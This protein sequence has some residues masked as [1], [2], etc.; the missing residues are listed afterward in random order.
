MIERDGLTTFRF[1][2]RP[3][4]ASEIAWRTWGEK[5]FQE[6]QASEKPILLAISAVWCH[7]CHVM[8]ETSYSDDEVIRTIN[9][10]YV[11]IRV[12]NDERPD[13][14]RRYNMGG[15]PTTA[16]LT[17]DGE[18]V[19]GGTYIPPDAMRSY[20]TQVADVWR[21]RRTE[22]AQRVAEIREKEREARAPKPADLSWDIVD[23]V[24]SHIRGAYDP[25]F[26]GFGR[27]PKFPQP[28]V[29]RF[30]LDEHRRFNYPELATM[31][32]KTLAAMAGGG[33]YDQVAGGFFRYA[34]TR[35]WEIPHYEKMLEDNAE[36]LAL[37]AEAHRSF[38][39][40]GYDRVVRDVVRWMDATL[41]RHDAKA[42]AGSQDADEHYY[43]LD[44]AERA[45]HD[46]PFVDGTIYSSWNAL[47]ASAYLAAAAALGD[48]R[49]KARAHDTIVTVANRM[50]REDGRLG[51]FDR[52]QG[53]EVFDLLG[54][55][56]ALCGA[57]LDG[58]ETG[59]HPHALDGARLAAEAIRDRL[60]DGENGGFFDAP[61]QGEP[62]RLA[63][64]E[65]PLEENALAADGLLRLSAL[66]G[67]ESWRALAL[68]TLRSFV[69]EYRQ[70][71]QFAASYAN[72]VAR[73]LAE[74]L[75]VTVVGPED[76]PVAG[77]LWQVA[78]AST[79]PARSLH[80]IVPAR[81]GERLATL[82]FPPDRTAAY[83]CVG[84]ACSEP[85][86]DEASLGRQLDEA[87][88]RHRRHD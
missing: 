58:Y 84:T 29:L 69:G 16:F 11:P 46:A 85:I 5:A 87:G 10:R 65:R 12:D 24:A 86:A 82:G 50:S 45:K 7:W 79:D 56:A 73:A 4:R 81:D 21:D 18:I 40:A 75:V 60:E 47:A 48:E 42:F 9:E 6:A 19:H 30:L 63:L 70:W 49:L 13:V 54:D 52:G 64:R 74:P 68:R 32:H 44:A 61:R 38:P 28:K 2:P 20:V 31:I 34:T 77:G 76:D 37:Y 55:L 57:M 59:A 1:S 33:M 14:N 43:T 17:P 26:G 62:G 3:N 83:V 15:W 78:R 36:L 41:W 39:S 8:D 80:R 66:S 88:A 72:A 51:H 67:D 25:Q 35:E 22:I 27:E 53:P 71:G 23:S